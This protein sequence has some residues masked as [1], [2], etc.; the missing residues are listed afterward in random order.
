[1]ETT[2]EAKLYGLGIVRRSEMGRAM[3]IEELLLK[4]GARIVAEGVEKGRKILHYLMP[5]GHVVEIVR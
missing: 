5:D 1:M 4:L 2:D 3:R